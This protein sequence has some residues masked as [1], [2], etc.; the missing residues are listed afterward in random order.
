[1]AESMEDLYWSQQNLEPEATIINLKVLNPQMSS[2]D[3]LMFQV[4]SEQGKNPS[5]STSMWS[6]RSKISLCS[7]YNYESWSTRRFSHLFISVSLS[8]LT[9]QCL[10]SRLLCELGIV[11]GGPCRK[12]HLTVL[13][14]QTWLCNAQTLGSSWR[15]ISHLPH[16]RHWN[17]GIY[18]IS[19]D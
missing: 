16:W 14:H 2:T 15:V 10:S 6:S 19:L 3:F 9:W 12:P 11:V 1:M 13:C 8:L 5:T 17:Q 18:W 7:Y 4:C